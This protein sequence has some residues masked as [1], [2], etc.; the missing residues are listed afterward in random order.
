MEKHILRDP[1]RAS[2]SALNQD[3]TWFVAGFFSLLFLASEEGLSWELKKAFS[4]CLSRNT[5]FVGCAFMVKTGV[6]E[7][8]FNNILAC[9]DVVFPWTQGHFFI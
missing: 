7:S 4:F 3:L 6:Q 9:K 8:T 1:N 5:F 2:W